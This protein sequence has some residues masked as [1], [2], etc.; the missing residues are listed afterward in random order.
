[1]QPDSRHKC[2]AKVGCLN[3]T[4]VTLPKGI[5]LTLHLLKTFPNMKNF[6]D[7]R[8]S[9]SFLAFVSPH[10]RPQLFSSSFHFLFVLDVLVVLVGPIVSL[11]LP[12]G[13]LHHLM[14]NIILAHKTA[15]CCVCVC[16]SLYKELYLSISSLHRLDHHSPL[17]VAAWSLIIV[18]KNH[19]KTLRK[20]NNLVNKH[21]VI[22][23][24]AILLLISV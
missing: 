1:M 6:M 12:L 18:W 9:L 2:L 3:S 20:N 17:A 22:N 16:F 21:P 7:Q 23:R 8:V 24:L 15:Q 19:V 11:R 5:G 14:K 13:F 4:K 10:V